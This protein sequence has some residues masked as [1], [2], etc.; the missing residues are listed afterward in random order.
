M[1]IQSINRVFTLTII[2]TLFISLFSNLA[3]ASTN[4]LKE[5]KN[6]S[7]KQIV[8]ITPSELKQ[9]TKMGPKKMSQKRDNGLLLIKML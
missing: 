9:N 2:F 5:T 8:K 1:R 4:M 6:T 3:F 7:D